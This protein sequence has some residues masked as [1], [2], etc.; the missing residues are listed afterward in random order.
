MTF[1]DVVYAVREKFVGS[2]VYFSPSDVPAGLVIPKEWKD[3]GLGSG[4][5][6][7]FPRAWQMFADELPWVLSLLDLCLIGTAIL[8]SDPIE[9]LYIFHD[10]NGLYYYTGGLPL[11]TSRPHGTKFPFK[12]KVSEFY[13]GLHNGFTFFPA[14]S[15]GPQRVENFTCVADLIDEEDTEFA[16]KWIT[17]LSNGAGDYLAVDLASLDHDKGV[18]WWHEEPLEPEIDMNVF[19][20]M[21]TWISIFLE[22]T[23][24]RANVIS[25]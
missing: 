10:A 24:P 6:S 19:E 11:E 14:R 4:S 8:E 18:I 2:N 22:D 15:M 20:V 12:G 3:F 17:L 23:Q 5:A 13:Q 21:D 16:S 25:G 9:L 7:K 1:D